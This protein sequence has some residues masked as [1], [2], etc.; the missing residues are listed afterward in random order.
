MQ[1]CPAGRAWR[2][3]A[4]QQWVEGGYASVILGVHV[5]HETGVRRKERHLTLGVTAVG[6]VCIRLDE[7][8]NRQA[9][10]GFCG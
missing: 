5:H 1:N 3:R 2:G 9:V 4:A 7:F 8:S 6:A 10:G